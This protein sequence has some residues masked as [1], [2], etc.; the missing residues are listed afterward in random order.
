M[1]TQDAV[2]SPPPQVALEMRGDTA[3]VSI[4]STSSDPSAT[5]MLAEISHMAKGARGKVVLDASRIRPVNCAWLNLMI[6]LTRQ[7]RAM[8]GD[9]VVSGLCSDSRKAIRRSGL[10]PL[11]NLVAKPEDGLALIQGIRSWVN[12]IRF[13]C[14]LA[15]RPVP[16]RA[17]A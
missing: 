7:C 12:L 8:G 6:E 11:L 9:L 2:L 15:W 5:G 14:P 3:V 13:I 16:Q 4:W 1:N 17:A 10:N